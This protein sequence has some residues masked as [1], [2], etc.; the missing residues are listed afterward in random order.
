LGTGKTNSFIT[1]ENCKN[2]DL[3]LIS[4]VLTWGWGLMGVWGE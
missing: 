1:Q 4:D 2:C 3:P